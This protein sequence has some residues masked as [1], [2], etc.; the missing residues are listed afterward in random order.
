MTHDWRTTLYLPG[1]LEKAINVRSKEFYYKSLGPFFTE[2]VCFDLRKRVEHTV[3]LPISE[4]VSAVRDAM[5]REIIR[6]YVPGA[7]RNYSLLNRLIRELAEEGHFGS[8]QKRDDLPCQ[9]PPENPETK[10]ADGPASKF[11]C[12]IRFPHRLRSI[13][14]I[15]WQ[16]LRY[17][18][19]GEYVTGLVRYDLMLGGPHTYFNGRDNQRY[20]LDSLDI[21]TELTFHARTKRQRILLDYMLEE[22]AGR[23][24]SDEERH[25][26]M[27]ALSQRLRDNA[28]K[29]R[30][31]RGG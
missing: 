5:D 11:G 12:K 8:W 27:I 15:R 26:A 22:V 4:Q 29:G 2:L 6:N 28:L 20:L 31:V 24:L 13:I 17:T 7:P 3:T 9:P 30:R 16:E 25:A 1:L 18:S 21:E 19:L 23:P 10:P 14:E